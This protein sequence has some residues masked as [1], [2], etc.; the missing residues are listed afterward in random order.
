MRRLAPAALLL[1]LLALG[2]SPV[3]PFSD[4]LEPLWKSVKK[5]T[6]AK[7]PGLMWQLRVTPPFPAEWPL[8]KDGT[9]VSYA[10]GAAMDVA[11]HDAERISPPFAKVTQGPK[12]APQVTQVLKELAV[13][14]TQGFHPI[15]K[16]R[17][18][19]QQSTYDSADAL[20]AGKLNEVRAAWCAWL[21]NNGAIVAQVREAHATFLAALQCEKGK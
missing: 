18:A 6:S 1:P 17:A 19:L 5:P 12:G 11:L 21:G 13:V 3:T 7:P 10:Y 8:K 4:L 2:A 16:E 9:V 20:R 14:D 15:T